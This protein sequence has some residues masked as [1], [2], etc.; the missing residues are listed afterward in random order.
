MPRGRFF[1]CV[2]L[3]RN[4]VRA[5]AL[6]AT[7]A[8]LLSTAACGPSG[9]RVVPVTGT[10]THNGEPISGLW[11]T[12]TPVAPIDGVGRP[13]TG[14]SK[15]DGSFALT[16]SREKKGALEGKHTVGVQF[17]PSSLE[18]EIAM[19][20]GQ[21]LHPAQQEI[22]AKYGFQGTDKIEVEVSRRNNHFELKLD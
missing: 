10:V 16:Y 7:C 15:P 6:V 1:S 4:W 5:A 21:K 8:V 22:T 19:G 3:G 2:L 14:V 12:F 20:R 17:R 18:E 11:I 9:P 13:S